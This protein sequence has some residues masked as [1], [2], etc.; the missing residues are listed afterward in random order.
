ME[1]SIKNETI[2]LEG[3]IALSC[4][5]HTFITPLLFKLF[6]SSFYSFFSLSLTKHQWVCICIHVE[7]ITLEQSRCLCIHIESHCLSSS[8]FSI[9]STL[10]TS[11]S[12]HD[13]PPIH[14]VKRIT[15]IH[16]STSQIGR[17]SC[18]ER[19]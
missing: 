16:L 3:Y 11:C 8:L 9:T 2:I 5:H 1:H 17:A 13:S 19:V 14:P 12:Y 4:W 15:N 7:S 6:H 10:N 18:R